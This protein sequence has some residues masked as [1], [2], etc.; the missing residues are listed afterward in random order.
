MFILLEIR[1]WQEYVEPIESSQLLQHSVVDGIRE[2]N[3]PIDLFLP[4]DKTLLPDKVLK[5]NCG[6]PLIVV[7]TKSDMHNEINSDELDKLQYHI[8][9]FCLHHGAALV[10]Y[11]NIFL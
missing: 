4:N 2:T 3:A 1:F 5:E 10:C 8:R 11:L 6:A 9:E 7:I